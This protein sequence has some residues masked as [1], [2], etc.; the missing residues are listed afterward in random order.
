MFAERGP[1][2]FPI[3]AAAVQEVKWPICLSRHTG[4]AWLVGLTDTEEWDKEVRVCIDADVP[5]GYMGRAVRYTNRCS[6]SL[7]SPVTKLSV[8]F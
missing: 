6:H 8:F 3:T 4:Y 7:Y 5:S 1:I 2:F